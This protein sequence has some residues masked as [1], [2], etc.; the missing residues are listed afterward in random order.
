MCLYTNLINAKTYIP[1]SND[2]ARTIILQDSGSGETSASVTYYKDTVADYDYVAIIVRDG[3]SRVVDYK[4]MPA[5]LYYSNSF[6]HANGNITDIY[7]T[8]TTRLIRMGGS[9]AHHMSV[10]GIKHGI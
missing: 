8:N 2:A 9:T 10:Y 6:Y 7:N 5:W 4:E 3:D 1:N